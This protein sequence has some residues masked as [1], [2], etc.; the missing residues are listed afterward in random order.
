MRGSW[1][2]ADFL[3]IVTGFL[4]FLIALPAVYGY[5]A[6]AL[7]IGSRRT[8]D[9]VLKTYVKFLGLTIGAFVLEFLLLIIVEG[10]ASSFSLPALPG[11]LASIL[12]SY[13]I[14]RTVMSLSVVGRVEKAVE[15]VSQPPAQVPNVGQGAVL[16]N[17]VAD[18]AFNEV[19]QGLAGADSSSE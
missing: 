2:N 10:P 13:L 1:Q 16:F 5:A 7:I 11:N 18:R 14:Y 15:A 19:A 4:T 6:I 8:A 12:L 17:A 3:W 9:R